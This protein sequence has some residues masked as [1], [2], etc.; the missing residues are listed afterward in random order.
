MVL[1]QA[2]PERPENV[3]GIWTGEVYAF[4]N[5]IEPGDLVVTPRR[6]KA[7]VSVG[8]VEGPYQYDVAASQPYWH[9]RAVNWI[10]EI[11]RTTLDTDLLYSFSAQLTIYQPRAE[12]AER[13]MRALLASGQQESTDEET[14]LVDLERVA[15]DQIAKRI[16]RRFKGNEMARLVGAILRAQGYSV[17]VSPAGPDR[18]VDLLAAPGALGFGSPKLCVQV[19]SHDTPVDAPTLRDLVGTMHSFGAEYGLLVSWGG[20]KNSVDREKA[21]KF[22]EVRLWD[23]DA[24]IQQLLDTYE[25]LDADIRA[26]LP[27]KRIWVLTTG[28]DEPQ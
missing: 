13:R 10:A 5:A 17:Y 25:R 21:S 4:V 23:Q 16:I 15:Y 8:V 26:E 12:D 19:K 28:E 2:Y 24:L 3:L 9:A 20:F 1:R 18:G 6:G 22:F 11:P 7:S 27:L 14:D